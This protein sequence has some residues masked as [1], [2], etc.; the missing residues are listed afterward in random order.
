MAASAAPK[1]TAKHKPMSNSHD[2]RIDAFLDDHMDPAE[3]Q[4]FLEL[5]DQDPRLRAQVDRQKKIDESIRRLCGG[6]AIEG[7][8]A[9]VEAAI[10]N[11]PVAHPT[12]GMTASRWRGLAVAALVG[13]ALVSVWYSW[14]LVKPTPA[15]DVYQPQPWRSFATVYYD[16]L[17][18]G[19]KPAWIC[20]NEKQF[21]TAFARQLHQ[22]LLLATLPSGI[23]AGGISYSNTM[24]P[25]TI[26]VLGRVNGTPVMIFVD[27]V[28]ADMGPLPPPPPDLHMFRRE[29]D[30][31][32]LYELTPLDK[33]EVLPYFY[34]PARN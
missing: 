5:L 3:R 12:I 33:A 10:A 14:N 24:T 18:D 31:L 9:R 22:P 11:E 16:T 7:L 25:G 13:L 30:D 32:V 19:F 28:A 34:R 2:P 17:R 15:V 20:R 23:T 8:T 1:A 21:E 29:I 27:R 26:N 4:A 6:A